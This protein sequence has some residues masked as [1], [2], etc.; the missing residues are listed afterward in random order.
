MQKRTL[1]R[2]VLALVLLPMLGL[3]TVALALDTKSVDF[4]AHITECLTW[5]VTDP[6]KHAQYCG[7]SRIDLSDSYVATNG[8]GPACVSGPSASCPKP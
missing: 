7:P 6:A 4:V 8:Y 1:S 3:P 2:L 5:L